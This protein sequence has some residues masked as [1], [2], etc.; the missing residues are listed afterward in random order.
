MIRYNE[1]RALIAAGKITGYKYVFKFGEMN[2]TT[3][4]RAFWQGADT[5][6]DY[7]FLTAASTMEAISTNAGDTAAGAGAR[8]IKIFGLDASFNEIEEEITMNGTS[9]SASTTQSFIRVFRAFVSESGSY[10]VNSSSSGSNLGSI[11]V[12]ET[13]AG[14]P[15]AYIGNSNGYAQTQQAIYTIPAGYTAFLY[16]IEFSADSTKV[17]DVYMWQ[18]ANADNFT[19]PVSARRIVHEFKDQGG[20]QNIV[21]PF[22][23]K[24]DEKTDIWLAGKIASGTGEAGG[25]FELLLIENSELEKI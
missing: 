5:Y 16:Q 10:I 25:S 17:I 9:A 12:R 3:A 8:K 6:G 14:E 4:F 24:F 23:L 11:T 20:N 7:N 2:L 13:G 21:F 19:P 1:A 22:P 15:Q 18:R